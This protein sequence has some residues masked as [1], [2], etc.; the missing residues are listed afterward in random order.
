MA[1]PEPSPLLLPRAGAAIS[2]QQ[3]AALL[4]VHLLHHGACTTAVLAAAVG[5]DARTTRD[6]LSQLQQVLD[7]RKE[8]AGPGARWSLPHAARRRLGGVDDF[9]SMHLG[10]GLLA[11]AP[12]LM[13]P[14]PEGP[15]LR[16]LER[17]FH[18]A[19]EPTRDYSHQ[20]PVLAALQQAL[21]EERRVELMYATPGAA[22]EPRGGLQPLCLVVHRG[23]VYLHA[24]RAGP[25]GPEERT[26]AVERISEVRLGEP[27]PYPEDFDPER[28]FRDR[29]QMHAS[30]PRAPEVRL[31]FTADVA[32]YVQ[33]RRWPGQLRQRARPDG[34]RDLVLKAEGHGLLSWILSW[35]PAVEVLSPPALR[36]EV[37][38]A[39]QAAAARYAA[40]GGA[41]P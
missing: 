1:L 37:I 34:G 4:L 29:W 28:T 38:G 39:L 33:A 10:R 31:R 3:R 2:P 20:G 17:K 26:Y 8:G 14:A 5:S 7:L 25:R 32:P 21:L 27:A 41:A 18:A 30:G 13:P 22:P 12:P 19:L 6:A 40:P 23:A 15:G 24:R 36:Q 11:F 16:H 9:V 35:G